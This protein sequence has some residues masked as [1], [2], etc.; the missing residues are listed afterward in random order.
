MSFITS[1]VKIFDDPRIYRVASAGASRRPSNFF[2]LTASGSIRAVEAAF[3]APA[4]LAGNLAE[5]T[6]RDPDFDIL[7]AI[8]I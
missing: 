8:F 6:A 1:G 3:D 2:L 4:D 7:R 5:D